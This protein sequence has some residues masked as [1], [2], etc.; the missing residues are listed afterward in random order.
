MP[1]SASYRKGML[2]LHILASS[3]WIGSVA[4]FL[5]LAITGFYDPTF[6]AGVYVAMEAIA[7]WLIVPLAFLSLLTGVFLTLGTQWG[8]FRHYWIL[9]KFLIN[10]VSLPILLLHTTIIHRV[11]GAARLHEL[12]AMRLREDR[13]QLVVASLAALV[14][15]FVALLLS[16]YKPKGVTGYGRR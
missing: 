8:L 4:A 12:S 10:L 5:V 6:P 14:A 9:F 16:V 13:L 15:L 11:A 1:L 2:L 3:G 7:S